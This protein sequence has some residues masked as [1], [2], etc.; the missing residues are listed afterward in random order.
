MSFLVITYDIL[1]DGQHY[2][3]KQRPITL[4]RS[5]KRSVHSPD[6]TVGAIAVYQKQ[7]FLFEGPGAFLVIIIHLCYV[8]HVP[9]DT[10][11]RLL[12]R[13]RASSVATPLFSLFF[14]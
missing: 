13:A 12:A 10:E 4:A 3:D 8:R 7:R 14:G 2:K 9:R 1:D 11:K 5:T 6:A